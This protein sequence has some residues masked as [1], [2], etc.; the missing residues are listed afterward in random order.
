[1]V[2]ANADDAINLRLKPKRCAR[3]PTGRV[4]CDK[5]V[6]GRIDWGICGPLKFGWAKSTSLKGL[7]Q[8][9]LGA[10][11]PHRTYC[12]VAMNSTILVSACMSWTLLTSSDLGRSGVVKRMP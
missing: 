1:M 8:R 11:K 12:L 3:R 4:D 5:K 9:A 7:R 2:N 6:S 10:P